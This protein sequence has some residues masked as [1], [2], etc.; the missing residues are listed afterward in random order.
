[1]IGAS[2]GAAVSAHRLSLIMESKSPADRQADLVDVQL[3]DVLAQV[4]A[5][6]RHGREIQR[7]A[8]RVRGVPHDLNADQRRAA[9]T[10]LRRR[11][12]QMDKDCDVLSGIVR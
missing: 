4:E 12:E 6:L 2:L 8:L 10:A 1:M 3:L 5:V 9:G 7:D 11:A